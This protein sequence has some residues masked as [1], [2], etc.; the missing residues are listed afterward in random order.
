MHVII[1]NLI[2]VDKEKW[3]QLFQLVSISVYLFIYEINIKSVKERF[4]LFNFDHDIYELIKAMNIYRFHQPF[5]SINHSANFRP[6]QSKWLW[7][8]MPVF[9]IVWNEYSIMDKSL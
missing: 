7:R 1:L 6:L 3:T 4:S 5:H 9:D 2:I 8:R